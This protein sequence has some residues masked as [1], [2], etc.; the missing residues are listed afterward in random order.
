MK[1]LENSSLFLSESYS[2]VFGWWF[3]KRK[4][5]CYY[6]ERQTD[7][8]RYEE[9]KRLDKF[10]YNIKV[11][12]IKKLVDSRDFETAAEVADSIDWK[13]VKDT[14]TLSVV[15]M[16]YERNRRYTDAK[17]I[18][19]LLYENGPGGRR[20]IYKLTELSAKERNFDEAEMF[21][22]EYTELAPDD[23]G[24]YTLRYEILAAQNAPLADQIEILEAYIKKEFDERWSYELARLY[25]KAGRRDACVK[26][27]DDIILWFSV[28]PFVERAARLKSVYAPLTPD[29]EEKVKNRDKYEAQLRQ[30]AEEYEIRVEKKIEEAQVWKEMRREAEVQMAATAVEDTVNSEESISGD[31]PVGPAESVPGDDSVNPTESLSEDDLAYGNMENLMAE[32]EQEGDMDVM[33]QESGMNYENDQIPGGGAVQNG[34]AGPVNAASE[35][36]AGVFMAEPERKETADEHTYDR[37]MEEAD[38]MQEAAGGN[39]ESDVEEVILNFNRELN[40]GSD[41]NIQEKRDSGMVQGLLYVSAPGTDRGMEY[42][43]EAIKELHRMEGKKANKVARITGT[44]LNLL[45]FGNSISK[46]NGADLV[47]VEAS[48]LSNMT[49]MEILRTTQKNDLQNIVVFVDTA[50]GIEQLDARAKEAMVEVLYR[51]EQEERARKEASRIQIRPVM[52]PEQSMIDAKFAMEEQA[53]SAEPDLLDLDSQIPDPIVRPVTLEQPYSGFSGMR[54][55]QYGVADAGQSQYNGVTGIDPEKIKENLV[56]MAENMVYQDEEMRQAASEPVRESR[57]EGAAELSVPAFVAKIKE[58]AEELDCVIEEIAGLAIYALADKYSEEGEILN[59]G[60]AREVTEAAVIRADKRGLG[61]LFASKYDKEGR[62]ILKEA[63]F[64]M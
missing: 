46:L 34:H 21:Y 44:K 18:L 61:G 3:D 26:L 63:H 9:E 15:S 22:R 57:Q 24:A 5:L 4:Q 16:I 13:R 28:G 32:A 54:Q 59:D 40:A 41:E 27:C 30:V 62:L 25:H 20:L 49:L 17:N 23:R 31:G 64:K 35:Q 43:T 11:E 6:Y 47:I 56:S 37:N 52:M 53:A 29:Q 1:S 51:I 60:L 12:K 50:E 42:A 33:N 10:E 8:K 39:W 38:G 14:R 48:Q 36:T 2:K 55:P 45:G 7:E 19:M 58:Y